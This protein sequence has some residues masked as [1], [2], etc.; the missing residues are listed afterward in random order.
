MTFGIEQSLPS[1][2]ASRARL[3]PVGICTRFLAQICLHICS[4]HL[5]QCRHS[6]SSPQVSSL[7]RQEPRRLAALSPDP[8]AIV[9]MR[10]VQHPA[11]LP[12]L[13]HAPAHRVEVMSLRSSWRRSR[14]RHRGSQRAGAHRTLPSR[15]FLLAARWRAR[16]SAAL[17][18]WCSSAYHSC[19]LQPSRTAQPGS[20]R[21]WQFLNA[22]LPGCQRALPQGLCHCTLT[23]HDAFTLIRLGNTSCH[24]RGFRRHS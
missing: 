8:V 1:L 2:L 16:S 5:A 12:L 13:L 20:S 10:Y 7:L 11:Q 6:Q 19:R 22:H 17:T 21:C 3:V 23:I 24:L 18:S 4:S 14:A 15:R 9:S